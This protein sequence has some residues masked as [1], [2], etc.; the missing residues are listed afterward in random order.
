MPRIKVIY[1][2]KKEAVRVRWAMHKAGVET[3][4]QLQSWFTEA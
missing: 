3:K 4:R 1:R 2:E